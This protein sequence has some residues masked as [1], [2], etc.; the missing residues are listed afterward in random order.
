MRH[1][2]A[3]SAWRLF[4][5]LTT[6]VVLAACSRTSAPPSR[7]SH[8]AYVWQRQWT[9]AV[10]R[11]MQA[12]GELVQTWHVLAAEWETTGRWAEVR[13]DWQALRSAPQSTRDGVIMTVRINGQLDDD[14]QAS[15]S[16]AHIA[17]LLQRWRDAGVRVAGV[18]IDYDC[19]TARL[20]SYAQ[21]LAGLRQGLGN[22]PL[23]ITALP[24][25]LES[26]A[27]DDVLAASDTVVLQVHAVMNPR[28][29]LFD[30]RR[31]A[32][33]LA[34]FAKRTERP[35]YVAL[36]TYGTRVTWSEDGR[37]SGIESERPMLA[38]AGPG[39]ASEL[40]A[41][42]EVI[43]AF[44]AQIARERPRGLAGIVWFRLPTE[45]DVRAWSLPTWLA[46]LARQPL[47]P[48]LSV[49]ARAG[50]DPGVHEV[51]L[52]NAGNADAPLP[53][54]VQLDRACRIA[55]GVN[56]YAL[57][58][59]AQGLYLQR[60]QDGLL[61]AGRRRTIGWLRCQQKEMTLHVQP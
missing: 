34:A 2:P 15:A 33:W 56:G 28:Q 22:M 25:W 36:P 1:T 49:Q 37:V 6:A 27:L 10:Q 35:W 46:I 58:T 39:P 19:A 23:S 7:L 60:T 30:A 14:L 45:D 50:A 24:T 61:R 3:P 41:R 9:P 4:L 26:P 47:T 52:V 54:A 5:A 13:P 21:W 55:D 44:V 59:G 38:A 40:A 29:G 20:P 32:A 17:G 42:P 8:D 12:S 51:V 57:E 18:E 43:D 11:A 48:V 53:A 31:A 16:I